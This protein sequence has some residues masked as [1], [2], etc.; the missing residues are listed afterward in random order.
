[1]FFHACREPHGVRAWWHFRRPACLRVEFYWW[2][3]HFGI[4]LGTDDEGWNISIKCP[5]FALYLSF[6]GMSL[7]QPS[8]VC[9]ATWDNNRAFTIPDEREFHFSIAEWTLR[10]ALWSRTWE[11]RSEDPWWIRGIS[12]DLKD[13]VLGRVK[14]EEQL[15]GRV[16]CAVPMPEGTYSAVATIHHVTRKRRRWLAQASIEVWLEIPKGIPYAGKGENSWDCG[17]DGLFGIGGDTVQDAIERAQASV[18][19]SRKRYGHASDAAIRE[20]LA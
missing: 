11:W 17:D 20:A 14:H 2:L 13:F 10:L 16:D 5:P 6:D 4:S 8:R 18:T 9:I 12:L 19:K 1:M 15:L 7:W 3:P